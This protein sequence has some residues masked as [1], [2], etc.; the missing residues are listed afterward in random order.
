LRELRKCRIYGR[1]LPTRQRDLAAHSTARAGITRKLIALGRGFGKRH[2]RA[3]AEAGGT[4][5]RA[6][7]PA[8]SADHCA[9]S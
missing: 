2:R 7:D 3:I 8:G 5:C 6:I 4:S 9:L 1:T